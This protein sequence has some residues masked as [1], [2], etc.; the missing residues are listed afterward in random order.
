M[1]SEQLRNTLDYDRVLQVIAGY[2][3]SEAGYAEVLKIEPTTDAQAIAGQFACLSEMLTLVTGGANF[4]PPETPLLTPQMAHL[5]TPGLILEGKEI[6][7]FGRLF[8]GAAAVKSYVLR[9]EDSLPALSALAGRLEE[10]QELRRDIERVFEENGDVRSSASPLLGKLRKDARAVR[11]RIEQRLAEITEKLALAGSSG[12]N[13]VTLR[14]ERYVLAILRSEMHSCPGIIQGESGSG[15]TLFIEPEQVVSLN[16]RFREIELDIRREIIRILGE[17]TARLAVERAGLAVDIEVLAR[18]DSLY[19]RAR[20]AASYRC[21]RPLVGPAQKLKLVRVRHP[22]LAVRSAETGQVVVPLDLE[23]LPGEKTLLVS[24]PNAGGKTVMLKTVGLAALLA[25][26]GIFPPLDEGSCLPVFERV[27]TAIGDEQ[28]I[29]KDLSSFSGH[30]AELKVALEEGTGTSLVLLDELGV[31]TDP[32]EGAGLAAAV[33]ERLTLMG[34]LT[35]ATTH[36]GELKVLHEQLTGLVNGSLEFDP[37][38]M[39]PTF[40]FRKGLPGQSYGLDIARNMGLDDSLLGRAR[41]YMSGAVVNVNDY[42]SRLEKKHKE[43]EAEIEKVRQRKAHLEVRSAALQAAESDLERRAAEITRQEKTFESRMEERLRRAMLDARRE[44]EEAIGRLESEY[45]ES[46]RQEAA[47]KARRE[48]ERRVS[49][50]ERPPAPEEGVVSGTP[51]GTVEISLGDKVRVAGLGLV[52]EVAEG[53]DAAGRYTV[54]AGR[55]RVSLT[56]DELE[57]IGGPKKPAAK[58]GGYE[59]SAPDSSDAVNR[60]LMRL[61]IRGLRVDEVGLELDRFITSA[62]LEGLK[63]VLVVHGKGTGAL[64]QKVAEMLA[65]DRRVQSFRLGGYY[66]GG[67][68]ATVVIL[69]G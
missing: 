52:G 51:A 39:R 20:F 7:S 25:Q 31:G 18:V 24:G 2:A 34:C 53:P 55:A 21:S 6:L 3:V 23:L 65:G 15:S 43:L 61:D 57:K 49:E 19:A 14:Q 50:L 12:E 67:I 1:L 46:D 36:Y 60:D 64:R 10:F 30:V 63:E 56:R 41:H 47:R 37:Q 42:V 11:E 29:D 54:V 16:N 9:R 27:I 45:A 59:L 69:A 44:V 62:V 22:L 33:L 40:I 5:A 68:G 26:S 4:I 48:V 17:L 13:F 66:E 58:S 35:I 38:R 8:E 32:A 28:S